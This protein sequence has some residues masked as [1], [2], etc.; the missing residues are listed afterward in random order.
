MKNKLF[1]KFY[2]ISIAAVVGAMIIMVTMLSFT[3][4]NYLTEEKRTTLTNYC[5][6]IAE[7][8][9]ADVNNNSDQNNYMRPLMATG[10]V[11]DANVLLVD[12]DGKIVY[13]SCEAGMKN[14]TCVHA[15]KTV[16]KST[17]NAVL[18]GNYYSIN[19][20]DG[21]FSEIHHSV[22]MPIVDQNKQKIGVL[23]A[24]SSASLLEKWIQSFSSMV[25]IC[26]VLP[27]LLT[28]VV[29]YIST[30]R[31][32]KPI[33]MMSEAARSL[34]RGDFSKRVYC[35]GDDEIAELAKSFNQ[36]TDSLVQLESMRRSFVANV[37]HE[38]R[39]PMTT[40]GGFID[41]ILDG[42]IPPE[43]HGYYLSIVSDEVKR[44]TRVVQSM[45]SLSRLESGEQEIKKTEIDIY[46]TVCEVLISQ[47]KQ[48]VEKNISVI[49]LED[50]EKILL[51]ADK[52]LLYQV[53]FN[54]ID[55]AIKFTSTD[56]YIKIG[57]E[58][59]ESKVKLFVR[60]SGEGIAE[61]DLPKVFERF[62]KVDKSRSADKKS[63]GLG[64]YIVK[65][66]ID[67]HKGTIT[68]RSVVG[69]YT[70]FE[71]VIPVE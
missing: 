22:G 33:K 32:L 30:M 36:M 63:S 18:N 23:F 57:F 59:N 7:T 47:E 39:T 49:G 46:R 5:K 14:N 9:A 6:A 38:L 31:I 13:C 48:I 51:T 19:N 50:Y 41:G 27:L 21:V 20:L 54:L 4:G 11:I 3:I 42:T 65:S 8:V 64:L 15:N 44:L 12:I 69:E 35:K 70:E 37:S 43:K 2:L 26:A 34:S 16:S 17:M 66:I 71:V 40:I 58:A 28:F 25:I 10:K 60:N 67:L 52:D 68:V 62:F 45:L 61:K 1:R 24:S 56:G 29:I 55:N 53:V